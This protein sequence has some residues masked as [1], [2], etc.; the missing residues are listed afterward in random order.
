MKLMTAEERSDYLKAQGFWCAFCPSSDLTIKRLDSTE[1]KGWNTVKCEE[2]GR[3]WIESYRLI[4]VHHWPE[5][6]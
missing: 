6:G 4:D 2:C 1:G 5:G 3:C